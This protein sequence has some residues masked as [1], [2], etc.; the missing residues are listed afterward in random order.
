MEK[1]SIR[2]AFI[3]F[4]DTFGSLTPVANLPLESLTPVANLPPVL[5]TPAEL[6]AKFSPG[7]VDTS[8]AH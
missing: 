3:I 2:K 4:F 8:G 6:V 7:V 5:T 1:T